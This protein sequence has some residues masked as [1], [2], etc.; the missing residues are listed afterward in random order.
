MAATLKLARVPGLTV[1]A[2]GCVVMV[3]AELIESTAALDVTG[4]TMLE[5]TTS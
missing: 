3:T 5:T 2:A 1:S 4:P